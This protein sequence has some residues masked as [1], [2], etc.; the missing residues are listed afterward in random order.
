MHPAQIRNER[1]PEHLLI[2]G[3]L[4]INVPCKHQC[5]Y[6]RA[7]LV[8]QGFIYRYSRIRCVRDGSNIY[9][10]SDSDGF[11][12]FDKEGRGSEG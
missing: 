8:Q 10:N 4:C 6:I 11:I 9:S 12:K 3:V 5:L 7:L 1:A 2:A